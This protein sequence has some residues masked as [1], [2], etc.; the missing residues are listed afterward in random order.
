MTAPIPSRK[1]TA[2]NDYR[3]T[4]RRLKVSTK[5][6]EL[7]APIEC[8]ELCK[9]YDVD[10]V[11]AV[12]SAQAWVKEMNCRGWRV[13]DT[14]ITEHGGVILVTMVKVPEAAVLERVLVA[15]KQAQSIL[16]EGD[17]AIDEYGGEDCDEGDW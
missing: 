17:V 10:G 3:D 6:N 11:P 16:A 14:C 13:R 5:H 1:C 2:H 4:T 8:T 12:R 15:A 7:S 9:F